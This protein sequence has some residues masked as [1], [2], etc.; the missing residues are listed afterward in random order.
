M[1]K[2]KKSYFLMFLI[3]ILSFSLG[4]AYLNSSLYINGTSIINAN[5]W[6]V[7]LDN[8]NVTAGSV[9]AI[10]EPVIKDTEASFIVKLENIDDYYEFT[11]DVV[12][13]GDVDAKL[14]S[15][16]ETSVLSKEQEK[17]FNYSLRYQ[18]GE[19]IEAEQIVKKDEFV[20]LKSKVEYKTNVN[21]SSITEEQKTLKIK[22]NLNYD[23]NNG[24]GKEV[25][26]NG[27]KNIAKTTGD[28]NEIGTVVS[29]GT[30]Q[31]Y[32]IGTEG[33][34]VKL[35]AMYN[36]YVGSEYDDTTGTKT[37]IENPTGMQSDKAKG[38]EISTKKAVGVT[39]FFTSEYRGVNVNDYNGSIVEK[40]VNDYKYIL[41]NFGAEIIEARLITYEEL[42]DINTF[43]CKQASNCSSNYPWVYSIAYWSQS[44]YEEYKTYYNWNIQPN[45]NFDYT[46][47]ERAEFFGVRPVI[48]INKNKISK[49]K[50]IEF[51]IGG[52]S[53]Q[54]EEWM[55]W[56]EWV[57][58][59]YNT[60]GNSVGINSGDILLNG[61]YPLHIEG[62]AKYYYKENDIIDPTLKY[63]FAA[64]SG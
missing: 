58:S 7:G 47:S 12:N 57:E 45:G 25:E 29:I 26:N 55:T 3:L 10:Q 24:N 43:A 60:Y 52:T 18:T 15:L 33:D 63:S 19:P 32:T 38:Y 23:L 28:I 62:S 56:G 46:F 39:P 17:Y 51:K 8:L 21:I 61:M 53:Y 31:F 30:E 4:Y 16:V 41:E 11:V 64:I 14:G 36:L 2:Y 13:N 6:E 27:V 22:F 42:T 5:V 44:P 40:Y 59:E 1:K 54:A 34:N 37:P 50:M 49:F 35:L 48:V 9:A 20:R